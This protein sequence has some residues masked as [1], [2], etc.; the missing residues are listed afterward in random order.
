MKHIYLKYLS[1][2]FSFLFLLV[3]LKAQVVPNNQDC[4]GAIPVCQGIYVQ[5]NSYIGTGNIPNEINPG[6]SCLLSGEKNDVWYV[7]TV[8]T[9]GILN[10]TTNFQSRIIKYLRTGSIC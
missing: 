2:L 6:N 7:F 5:N 10:F 8:Q 9:S 1:F 3:E 4:L